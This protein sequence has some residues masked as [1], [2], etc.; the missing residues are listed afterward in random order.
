[1]QTVGGKH[2]AARAGRLAAWVAALLGPALAVVA[3]H[4][5]VAVTIDA[6]PLAPRLPAIVKRASL[7]VLG[8]VGAMSEHDD[9]RLLL[10][11]LRVARELHGRPM[12]SSVLAVV[13]ERRFAAVSPFLRTG[14]RV[15]AFLVVARP[16]TQLR[17][18]LPPGQV[19]YRFAE[20][21]WGL[22]DLP[23]AD[24]EGPV[25]AAVEGWIALTRGEPATPVERAAAE[26]RLVFT[27]IGTGQPRLVED[28]A[29]ALAGLPDLAATLTDSERETLARAV[30]RTD[31]P[32]RLRLGLVKAIADAHLRSLADALRDLPGAGP[33]LVRASALARAEL[34]SGPDRTEI[35]TALRTGDAAH[36]AALVPALLQPGAGGIPAVSELALQDPA[37]EV[38][39]AAIQTLGESGSS[40][41]LPTLG[42]T[43]GDPD[44]EVRKTTAQAIYTIGGRPA[45]ELLGELAFA[46]PGDG[47]RQAVGMLLLLELDRDDPLIVRIRDTHPDA[48]VRKLVT[49]GI[50]GHHH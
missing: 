41:A 50:E 15:V 17:R 37:R 40:E 48:S 12:E 44:A 10:G 45:A 18:A 35:D 26:R 24:A 29:A 19:Y 16:T 25:V 3:P 30:R 33:S 34:G 49:T 6:P 14:R 42:K 27:E 28:G 20:E 4:V 2:G 11:Q 5:A 9:G 22:I 31:L 32:E 13:E 43:F 38:R 1:M 8:D 7:V 21:R 39:L 23:D 47:Q 36:R 46:A